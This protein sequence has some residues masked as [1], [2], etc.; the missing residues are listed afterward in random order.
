MH[1]PFGS[2]VKILL[3]VQFPVDHVRILNFLITSFF[4]Q[5]TFFSIFSL[6]YSSY[7]WLLMHSF[8]S[9]LRTTQILKKK[10]CFKPYWYSCHLFNLSSEVLISFFSLFVLFSDFLFII[11]FVFVQVFRC[12]FLCTFWIF[13]LRYIFLN[14]LFLLTY[15]LLALSFGRTSL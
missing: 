15:S 4:I 12:I 7:I 8:G 6:I 3:L 9:L 2:T 5:S 1:I 13:W 10:F 11:K 14:R